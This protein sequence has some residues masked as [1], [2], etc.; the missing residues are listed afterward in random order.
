MP[1]QLRNTKFEKFYDPADR[2]E[3]RHVKERFVFLRR[4]VACFISVHCDGSV[5]KI[6]REFCSLLFIHNSSPSSRLIGLDLI[7]K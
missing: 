6:I 1:R 2:Y 3:S 4:L 5:F 7:E